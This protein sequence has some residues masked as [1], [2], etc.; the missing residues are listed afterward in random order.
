MLGRTLEGIM[1]V[2]GYTYDA[3]HHC[4]SCTIAYIKGSV[5]TSVHPE[6]L[7]RWLNGED[8]FLDSEG[9]PIHPIFNTDEWFA[10]DVYEG[11]THATLACG[12]CGEIIDEMT[13][14]N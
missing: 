9:N 13:T 12:T 2:I 3:D 7:V 11:R 8:E 1:K 10:N 4:T 5:R 14:M 6:Q